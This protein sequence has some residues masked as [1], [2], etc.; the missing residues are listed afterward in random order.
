[1]ASKD[2]S[3]PN[4]LFLISDDTATKYLGCYGGQVLTP[5]LDALAADG[6][7][8]T[9][10]HVP[11]PVCTPSRYSYQ[12]GK[13]ASRG[14]A[15]SEGEP[16]PSEDIVRV[17]F[18]A[19]I[20]PGDPCLATM[21]KGAG[22]RTGFVGKVHFAGGKNEIGAVRW[23]NEGDPHDPE[24][25]A[26]MKSNQAKYI[27]RMHEIGWDEATALTWG[28]IDDNRQKKS[29][30]HNQEWLTAGALDI[31]EKF[32]EGGDPF[33]L[34]MSTNVIH[35]PDH[36]RSILDLDPR[37][38]YGG[39]LD[40][41]PDVQP[42]R[43]SIVDRLEAAGLP[44]SHRTV[45]M[46]W[47]DDAFGVLI[48]RLK[49]LGIYENTIIVYSADHGVEGKW[50]CHSNGTNVPQIWKLRGQKN[51]GHRSNVLIQ[52]IDFTPTI[53]DLCGVEAPADYL[54][55][56]V[57][58]SPAL[59]GSQ[60]PLREELYF[61]FGMQRGIRTSKWK[62][63][64]V[65]YREQDIELMK[66][67]KSPALNVQGKPGVSRAQ[68]T[69][70]HYWDADQLYDWWTDPDEQM[71]IIDW[72]Q[73]REAL[74]DMKGRLKKYTDELNPAYPAEPD[75]FQHSSMYQDLCRSAVQ[76]NLSD[77]YDTMPFYVDG[78]Y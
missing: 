7:L 70:S 23:P 74:S 39:M 40:E 71:N 43:Q 25:D 63:L 65:R 60:N 8:F 16:A 4:V 9:D 72:P 49:E 30:I 32:S 56:G 11:T 73:N 24:V 53:L 10:A 34:T 64:T 47:I 67:G 62:Y 6:I 59:E 26:A 57:S 1:M 54:M 37:S 44:A 3:R 75:P 45:G 27:A 78:S 42:S 15:A 50:S 36:G 21:L 29:W 31:M 13:Y 41:A 17:G 38:C 2:P 48:N 51:A 18:N 5:N 22:Y 33:Y 55:D 66:T 14:I 12:T 20:R 35:G 52:N 69:H 77:L 76:V 61:E 46:L 28:N 68:L 58:L 19:A